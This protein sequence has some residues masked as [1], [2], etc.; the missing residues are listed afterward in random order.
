MLV[1]SYRRADL[2]D[3]C[4]QAVREH[5]P[6]A[7]VR[8]WD[9]HSEGSADVRELAGQWPEV[10]W[11]F[12]EENVGF[13]AAVNGLMRRVTSPTAFLLN[14]DATLLSDLAGCRRA[15]AEDASVAAAAPN[16]D[17]PGRL[18]W[19][20]AHREP[21]WVR[22]L[23]SFAGW[24]DRLGRFAPV[25]MSYRERP[26]DVGGYLTGAGLLISMEA[27]RAV[28]EFDERYFL[29]GEEADWCHRA[30]RRG[31][32]LVSVDEPG[33][34]HSAA[35][36]VSDEVRARTR[37]DDLLAESRRRYV[38]DQQGA[39]AE[40]ALRAGTF[41]LER[42]QRSK[43][44]QRAAAGADSGGVEPVAAPSVI[45]TTPTLGFGGA[46]RQR[47]VL[48]NGLAERG[49]RV[50]LRALQAF[51]PLAD[52]LSPQVARRLDSFTT[53]DREAGPGTLLV[54]GTSRIEI[55][56][57]LAWRARN[58]PRGR[59]V[60]ANHQ[61]AEADRAAFERIIAA[62]MLPADGMIYLSQSHRRDH[63][64]H[65]RL[66][67]GRWWVV[68]NGIDVDAVAAGAHEGAHE[69]GGEGPV[70]LVTASRVAEVK[71]LDLLVRALSEGMDDLDWTLDIWG[72]G[73]DRARVEAAI[74]AAMRERI[75]MRG[76]CADVPA[77]LGTADV[78][79]LPSRAEAQP[80][81]ILEAMAAGT[82]VVANPV[83]AV[84]EMLADGAAGFL[85]EPADEH[86]WREVLRHVITSPQERAR[87]VEA[88]RRRVARTYSREA[89]IAGYLDVRDDLL[90]QKR[91]P[92]GGGAR[93]TQP[94]Q[95]ETSREQPAGAC[96][97]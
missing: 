27:W 32:R 52:D 91:Q 58:L 94:G 14:P 48:A 66:D 71:Q 33:I 49:E 81:T 88:A 75:R 85:V 22:H 97:P 18:P 16:V 9:N 63:L 96:P 28:G 17:E 29:Y 38:R 86:G 23:L 73:P 87:R 6:T 25:S 31:L 50:Q 54:T 65:Q 19:D 80:M 2:L 46:E 40:L 89:M 60:I 37:S 24:E 30:R 57:G 70:R 69:G 56:F 26:I 3:T 8:V 34:A 15:L 39:A 36:T 11:V 51:G 79:C 42:V 76:W 41:T 77:M 78:L 74:P 4:L 61:P 95:G 12:S 45:I 59:W 44:A 67:H 43:R 55:A 72:E 1:V 35:G 47:V 68:P 93:A 13:A 62:S 53:V 10:D 5:L 84:P 20:N 83:A 92:A 64:R 82:T 7:R 90:G 21:T